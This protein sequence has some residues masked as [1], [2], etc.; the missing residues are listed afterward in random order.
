MY[1]TCRMWVLAIFTG[2]DESGTEHNSMYALFTVHMTLTREGYNH[3]AD[4]SVLINIYRYF[5]IKI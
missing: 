1:F 3:L 4:V 2:N 5:V